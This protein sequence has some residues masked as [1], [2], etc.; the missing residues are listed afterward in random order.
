MPVELHVQ[1]DEKGEIS[2]E[3]LYVQSR[4]RSAY[5]IC[6]VV[7]VHILLVVYAPFVVVC[8][9]KLVPRRGVGALALPL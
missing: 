7:L 8:S 4:L 6:C 2:V 3:C 9:F 1:R 5:V